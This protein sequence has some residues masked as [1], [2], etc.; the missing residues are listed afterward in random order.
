MK[1]QRYFLKIVITEMKI[2]QATGV[3]ESIAVNT[4]D[5]VVVEVQ[6]VEVHQPSQGE[7]GEH[8]EAVVGE[9]QGVQSVQAWLRI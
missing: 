6:V 4:E 8:L 1:Y 7:V 2:F 9:H 5:V 3:F